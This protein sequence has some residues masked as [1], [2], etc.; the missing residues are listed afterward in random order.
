MIIIVGESKATY[1][2]PCRQSNPGILIVKPAEDCL[3]APTVWT[4][5]AIGR[6]HN[7]Q[8]SARAVVVFHVRQQ[9]VPQVRLPD[10]HDVVEAFPADR[11]DQF[12]RTAILPRRSRR[13]RLVADA[14]RSH[15]A[16]EN[17]AV[18]GISITDQ[19]V[20]YRLPAA[21]FHELIGEPLC[22]RMCGRLT[23]SGDSVDNDAER[24]SVPARM[25]PFTYLFQSLR[26][27]D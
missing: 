12:L 1:D 16:N 11:A 17:L 2:D 6:V 23:K 13:D 15:A 14:Q 24:T 9:N 7:G 21:G 5:G 10:D 3:C 22:R 18:V 26:C 19:K 4:A 8:M 25:L 20:G 27:L